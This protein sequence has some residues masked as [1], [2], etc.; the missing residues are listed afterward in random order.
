LEDGIG[1][2]PKCRVDVTFK[3]GN[4][5]KGWFWNFD[6]WNKGEEKFFETPKGG[7]TFDPQTID[8]L[9]TFPNTTARIE[10][11]LKVR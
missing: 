5:S 4:Q 8:I 2:L 1:W 9:I 7:L 11:N 10:R 6:R 3:N